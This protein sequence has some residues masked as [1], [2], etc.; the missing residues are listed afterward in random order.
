MIIFQVK[1]IQTLHFSL[2]VYIHGVIT[3]TIRRPF[4]VLTKFYETIPQTR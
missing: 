3:K 2:Y 1:V 4:G